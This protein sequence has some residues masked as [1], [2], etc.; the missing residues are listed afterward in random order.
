[1]QNRNPKVGDKIKDGPWEGFE[2]IS[3]YTSAQVTEDGF[4]FDLDPLIKAKNVVPKG[5]VDDF[6]I[7]YITTSVLALGYWND[8][9]INAVKAEDAGKAD[10]CRSCPT[11]IAFANWR[12]K[13]LPCKE[14]TLNIPNV[15]DLLTAALRI[16]RKK[17]ENDYFVSGYV[18]LPDGTRQTVYIAQN[19]TG[20]Y[21]LMLPE[22]D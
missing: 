22:D 8:R 5:T 20:R 16:F 12:N 15:L 14:K 9:C 2:L 19:E 4:L 18:Q 13:T 17:P 21:T 1:V 7:K 11:W 3:Q 10:R 6:P